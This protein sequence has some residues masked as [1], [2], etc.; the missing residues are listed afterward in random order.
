MALLWLVPMLVVVVAAWSRD[1]ISAWRARKLRDAGRWWRGERLGPKPQIG[2]FYRDAAG[3]ARWFYC[4]DEKT[5]GARW[6]YGAD[7][8]AWGL[9]LYAES[10]VR[11]EDRCVIVA[12]LIDDQVWFYEWPDASDEMELYTLGVGGMAGAAALRMGMG[13]KV[14]GEESAE[15]RR[16]EARRLTRLRA[17]PRMLLEEEFRTIFRVGVDEDSLSLGRKGS[18]R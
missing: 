12:D 6:F 13:G 2:K 4:A 5:R 1:Q 14:E 7:D 15:Q 11:P 9:A 17:R 18:Y 16:R 3:G 10:G 8:S